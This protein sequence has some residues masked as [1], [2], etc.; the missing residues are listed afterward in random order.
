MALLR[1]QQFAD[2]RPSPQQLAWQDLEIGVL[3]HFGPNT[4]MDR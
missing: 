2:V 4:W 1:G 3:I